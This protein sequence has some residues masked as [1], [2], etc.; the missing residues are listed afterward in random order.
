MS[1]ITVDDIRGAY[2][3]YREK[4][5]DRNDNSEVLEKSIFELSDELKSLTDA[6]KAAEQQVKNLNQEIRKVDSQLTGLMLASETQ[7]FTRNGTLFYLSTSKKA[8]M[9]AELKDV[10]FATLK[11]KGFGSLVTE[12]VNGNSL[13]AFVKEQIS[14]NENILPKWLD[15]LVNIYEKIGVSIRKH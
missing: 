14:Q 8:S 15:G 7:N 2:L 6:K 11:E 9:I 4:N 1:K 10:L 12:T 5:L 13:S 3:A